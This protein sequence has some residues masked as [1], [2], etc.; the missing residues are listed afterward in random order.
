MLMGQ[1]FLVASSRHWKENGHFFVC[2]RVSVL[3]WRGIRPPP[4]HVEI[5]GWTQ[6]ID[7]IFY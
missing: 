4:V 1:M 6:K 3:I 5:D 7:L 2:S